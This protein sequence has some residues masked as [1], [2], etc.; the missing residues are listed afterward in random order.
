MPHYQTRKVPDLQ[1][2]VLFIV[3]SSCANKPGYYPEYTQ[4]HKP[5]IDRGEYNI[6]F[7]LLILPFLKW[8]NRNVD[9]RK[10]YIPP[11]RLLHP[12]ILLP[13]HTNEGFPIVPMDLQSCVSKNHTSFRRFLN[14]QKARGKGFKTLMKIRKPANARIVRSYLERGLPIYRILPS[15]VVQDYTRGILRRRCNSALPVG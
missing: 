3:L 15:E 13:D 2:K 4:L 10:R 9:S 7:S 8:S 14:L 12:E 6:I 11:T 1:N 5:D